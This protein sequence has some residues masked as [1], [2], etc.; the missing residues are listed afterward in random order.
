MKDEDTPTPTTEP[1]PPAEPAAFDL[2]R[3]IAGRRQVLQTARTEAALFLQQSAGQLA[4]L[5]DLEKAQTARE[6]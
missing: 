1:T 2:A 5:D 4:L 6:A 3:W